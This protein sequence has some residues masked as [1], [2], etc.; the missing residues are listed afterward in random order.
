MFI[1]ISNII[2]RVS[3]DF[4]RAGKQYI[5]DTNVLLEDPN[6]LFKLRKGASFHQLFRC[7]Y[8]GWKN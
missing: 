7:G 5:I 3:L 1:G 6:A 2:L 8:P 4:L